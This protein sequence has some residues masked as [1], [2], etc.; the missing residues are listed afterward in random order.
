MKQYG[1]NNGENVKGNRNME[2]V[3][4]GEDMYSHIS[5]I[6]E[7]IREK[8]IRLRR[9]FHRH[10]ET[11]WLEMRTSAII[12][13][14]LTRLGYEV[15]TGKDV[16]REGSRLSVPE[17]SVLADHYRRIRAEAAVERKR[18]EENEEEVPGYMDYLT[19]EMTEGYTGVVGILRCGDGPVAA[20][21]FDIDALPMTEETSDAHRPAREGFSS[22]N[23]GMM[24]ACGHDCHAA[25]GLGAAQIL[26]SV[27]DQLRGTVKLLFQ[28]GEEGVK[29]AGSM[30]AAGHLDGVDYFAGT[31]VAPY[32]EEDDGDVT[33]GT[34]G[35]L[36]TC[37]YDV[38]FHGQ[39]CHAG[40]FPEEG[41][42]AVLAAAHAT[43]A[44]NGI[45]RHSGGIT[46]VN[47]GSING[48]ASSNVVADEAVISMEVRGETTEINEYMDRRAVEICQA[49]AMMEGC[50]C[51][52]KLM[53]HAPSQVS[54]LPLIRRIAAMVKE[55]LP[56]Y[57]VSRL[58]NAK[59]WGSED[60]GFMM[61]RVQEQGGQAVYMRT[62]TEMASPQHTSRFD[63][64]ESVLE[65]GAVLFASI[66][67]DLIGKQETKKPYH[68]DN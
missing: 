38:F 35:S 2:A 53:G 48:G 12:A 34:Y 62:M 4:E 16:C 8:L 28:P 17:K 36:A 63:V 67:Y 20:L 47:I 27:R 11:G 68:Y 15:L 23:H 66:V 9:D 19:T 31:H 7:E 25:I 26:H 59:N 6:G 61:K 60:I 52:M 10:P 65:K 33:P 42:N 39:S 54:D 14:E 29:G 64:D 50:T 44:L 24:H 40:G 18:R 56:Q 49:A 55:N 57:R 22:V 13:E 21:R 46:R 1:K 51:E 32:S 45:A 37:K 3:G 58:M 30:V 41:R 5:R 43:V